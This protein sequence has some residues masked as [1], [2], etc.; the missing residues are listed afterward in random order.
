VIYVGNVTQAIG[1]LT[2]RLTA[3]GNIDHAT[4]DE[5]ADLRAIALST[6]DAIDAAVTLL[7]PEIGS[8]QDALAGVASGAFPIDSVK[9]L[10]EEEN[11]LVQMSRLLDCRA[12]AG[13]IAIN[14]EQATG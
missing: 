9:A 11:D 2:S 3:A 13:R 4:A 10:V 12:F 14:L 7:D 5:I 1:V 6:S 8:R